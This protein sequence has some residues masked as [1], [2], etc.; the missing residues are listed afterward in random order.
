MAEWTDYVRGL[1]AGAAAS[2]M[3]AHLDTGCKPCGNTV[4]ILEKL[5]AVIA[6]DSSPEVPQYV[7]HNAK[8]LF[9]LQQPEKISVPSQIARL[10]YDSFRQP[11]T[12]GVR[13]QHRFSRHAVYQAGELYVDLRLDREVKGGLISLVGQVGHGTQPSAIASVRVSL[14]SG[15]RVVAHTLSNQHGEFQFEYH[16]TQHLRLHMPVDADGQSIE[17]RLN[18]LSIPDPRRDDPLGD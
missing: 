13:N 2:R 18:E 7:L 17:V 10:V 6:A 3:K 8:S 9:A 16:P 11:L 5:A 14:M 4:R 1:A 15:E 12:A